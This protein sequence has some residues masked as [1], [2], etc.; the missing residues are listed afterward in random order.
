M[1]KRLEHF[2]RSVAFIVAIS[3]YHFCGHDPEI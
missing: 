1:G 2:Q 3:F